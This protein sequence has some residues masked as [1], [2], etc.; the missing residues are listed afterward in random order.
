MVRTSV[1]RRLFSVDDTFY[2]G[3]GFESRKSQQL[4]HN[5]KAALTFYWPIL[6]RQIRLRG[7]V[8][9]MGD[10]AG[11]ADFRQRSAEDRAVALTGNQSQE[12]V[13]EEELEYS[14][15]EQR[16]RISRN[17]D[18]TTL[19][20]RLYALNVK[21]AEIWQGDTHRKHTRIQYYWS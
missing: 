14:L 18:I 8:E 3:S 20:W 21:E 5:P 12:L 19:N 13:R 15:A 11:A 1:G 6:G 10:E 2:F 7:T 9:D 17:Q 4:K 16:E